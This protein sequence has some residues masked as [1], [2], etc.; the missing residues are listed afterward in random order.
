MSI[1]K[2]FLPEY[3]DC[4][5][6]NLRLGKS[7]DLYNK[8]DFEIDYENVIPLVGV[9]APTNIEET[10]QFL[11]SHKNDDYLCAIKLYETYK[12]ITP[13]IASQEC[14]WAYLT[15]SHFF[16]YTK[17]RWYNE[18]YSSESI[19]KR[20]FFKGNR[21][22]NSLYNLW[23]SVYLTTTDSKDSPY[24]L[25]K[26]LFKNETFRTRVF[27]TSLLI[28]HREAMIGILEFIKENEEKFT[29][30]FEDNGRALCKFFN[31]VGATKQISYLDK[32]YFK[33]LCE[34]ISEEIFRM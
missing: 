24:E 13:L 5:K 23:W 22:L 21:F 14:F 11:L 32:D 29:K 25:T 20:W 1:Q 2:I 16:K 12:N 6:Q 4:L 28:R 10:A 7:A 15:H 34:E 33:H 27:G 31:H 30:S 8:E 19:E 9:Q 17:E 3:T 18:G 26:I